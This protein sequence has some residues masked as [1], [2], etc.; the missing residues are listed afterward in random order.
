[1]GHEQRRRNTVM[2]E[3]E[4]QYAVTK[5]KLA[6]LAE[7]LCQIQKQRQSD[8]P[9]EVWQ[10]DLFSIRHLMEELEGEIAEFEQ[11]RAGQIPSLPLASILDDLPTALTRAR[12]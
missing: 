6:M 2:I 11:L 3:N 7:S 4:R 12:I 10:S 5:G 9:E 1:M 8:L